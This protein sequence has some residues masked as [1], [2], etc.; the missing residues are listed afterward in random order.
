MSLLIPRSFTRKLGKALLKSN[1]RRLIL[2]RV[3]ADSNSSLVDPS[4]PWDFTVARYL[5]HVKK[6]TG[7]PPSAFFPSPAVESII[8]AD[9][10]DAKKEDPLY[11]DFIRFCFCKDLDTLKEA[12]KR[13]SNHQ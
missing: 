12:T 8:K 13:L 6:V 3:W 2:F 1:I 11:T 7:I 10:D 4:E 5:T 9:D